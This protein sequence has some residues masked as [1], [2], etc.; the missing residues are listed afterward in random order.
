MLFFIKI[1]EILGKLTPIWPFLG[2][3]A[4]VVVLIAILLIHNYYSKKNI[5][6][7]KDK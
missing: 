6:I 4:E 2:F 5:N 7:Q 3:I 1:F